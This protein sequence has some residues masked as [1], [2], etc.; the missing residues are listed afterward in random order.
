MYPPS[1]WDDNDVRPTNITK[2]PRKPYIMGTD[3][4]QHFG[5]DGA[6]RDYTGKVED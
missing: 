2:Q 5:F 6:S 3:E 1:W 4:K